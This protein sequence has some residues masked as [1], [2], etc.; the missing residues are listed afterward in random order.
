MSEF[1]SSQT[2]EASPKPLTRDFVGLCIGILAVILVILIVAVC[3]W[4]RCLCLKQ[5]H[6]NYD[7]TEGLTSVMHSNIL[8]LHPNRQFHGNQNQRLSPCDHPGN[9]YPSISTTRDGLLT[10]PQPS[11]NV[12]RSQDVKVP[13]I[14]ITT[15]PV[16]PSQQL[17]PRLS[18]SPQVSNSSITRSTYSIK[19]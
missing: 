7:Q 16:Q 5:N 18:I 1:D 3:K 17:V 11:Y 15:L 2:L 13:R 10:S 9:G 19:Q 14:T 4:S 6:N 8:P 12:Y